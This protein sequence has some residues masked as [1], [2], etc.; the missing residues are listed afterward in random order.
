MVLH[1][2]VELARHFGQLGV[3]NY[4]T[5]IFTDSRFIGHLLKTQI[6]LNS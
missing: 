3:M 4:V 1:R 5:D 6:D 2:P